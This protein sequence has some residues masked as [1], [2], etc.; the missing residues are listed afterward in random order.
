MGLLANSFRNGLLHVGE[1][2]ESGKCL[3]NKNKDLSSDTSHPLKKL[4]VA[5]I[6]LMETISL[7][8]GRILED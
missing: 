3:P 2:V 8:L 5:V 1:T 6:S 4:S 7:K